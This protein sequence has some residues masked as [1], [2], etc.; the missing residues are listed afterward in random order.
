MSTVRKVPMRK[1]VGCGEMKNKKELIRVL[2]TPGGRDSA[3]CRRQKKRPG[4]L[5][6]SQFGLSEKGRAEQRAGA[7]PWG[8]GSLRKSM[9]SFERRWISLENKKARFLIGLSMKAGKIAS[10]EF[11]VE[12]AVKQGTAPSGDP[13]G[14]RFRQHGEEIPQYVQ[15]LPGCPWCVS[16]TKNP[17]EPPSGRDYRACAAVLEEHL[18]EEIRQRLEEQQQQ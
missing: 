13:G 12:K 11:A 8:C 15:L 5:S 10:G 6:L 1:C 18:A 17:W 4:S 16:W 7:G 9:R 14:R 2:K 3:G